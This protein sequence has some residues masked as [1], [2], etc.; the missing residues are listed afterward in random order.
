MQIHQIR[1]AT[2]II[3]YNNKKF[4][5]DPWLGPQGYMPGFEG[6]YHSEVRQPRIDLP[7]SI[8]KI[9]NVDAVIV[10]HYH[11]DHWDEYAAEALD[12]DLP[13]FVQSEKDAQIY[14]S[15]GFND[16]RILSENGTDFE[17]IKL[18]KTGCQ[19]GKRETVKAMCESLGFPYESMGVMF[20][21]D[22]EKTLYLAGD[23]IWCDEVKEAI[24]EYSPDVIIVNACGATLLNNEHI[25]MHLDDLKAVS[26]FVSKDTTIIASHLD[27]VSHLTVTREDIKALNLPNIVIP[28]NNE[29][30]TY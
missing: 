10:T 13:F 12:K 30:L 11:P 15:L 25:I 5:T 17:G 7:I 22:N 27:T 9:V 28:E 2:L 6:A 16:V 18:Y 1:S 21:A 8:E 24:N 20:K 4:L 26:A 3:T 29:C 19:H 14:K 23:T